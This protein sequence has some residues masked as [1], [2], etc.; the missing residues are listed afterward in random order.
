[1][2]ALLLAV[3]TATSLCGLPTV[4]A[5]EVRLPVYE[6]LQEPRGADGHL[7]GRVLR[8]LG[9]RNDAETATLVPVN[10]SEIPPHTRMTWGARW[11]R[12]RS[13]GVHPGCPAPPPFRRNSRT[14]LHPHDPHR[15][16]LPLRGESGEVDSRTER[17]VIS[18]SIP[19][20]RVLS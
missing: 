12:G 15:S 4:Q 10:R 17:P 18:R 19:F 13:R 6:K 3:V 8:G 16:F 11:T 9:R 2:R 14:S 5:Q 20:H 7:M 1:M